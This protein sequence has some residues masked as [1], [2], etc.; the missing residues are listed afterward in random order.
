MDP[1]AG[2][3]IHGGEADDLAEFANRLI[4]GDRAQ[5][6]LV[7]A[8]DAFQRG[9]ARSGDAEIDGIDRDSDIVGAVQ[10]E[11]ARRD[12]FVEHRAGP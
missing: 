8:R 11:G 4:P 9:D 2:R 6:H 10:L 5:R 7:A 3:D 12:R 1:V